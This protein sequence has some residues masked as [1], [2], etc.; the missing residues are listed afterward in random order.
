MRSHLEKGGSQI[1]WEFMTLDIDVGSFVNKVTVSYVVRFW[2]CM[3]GV[4]R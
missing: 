3:G 4:S 1:N 2:R